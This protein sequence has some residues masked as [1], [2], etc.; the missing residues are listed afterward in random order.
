M[1]E[2]FDFLNGEEIDDIKTPDEEMKE[3]RK[4]KSEA[5]ARMV[6]M[7]MLPYEV[8]KRRSELRA[9]EFV[10]QMD[11]RGLNAHVSVG[12]LDSIT[13]CVFPEVMPE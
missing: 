10:E 1:E 2:I 6:A 11:E 4:K 8:K 5:R 12:G 13:L 3:W 7:Q 9:N